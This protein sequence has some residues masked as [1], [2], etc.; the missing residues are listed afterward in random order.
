MERFRYNL[1]KSKH[2]NLVKETLKTLLL[3][4]MKDEFLESLN[5][6]GVGDVCHL[7]YDDVCKLCI[8]YSRGISKLGKNSREPSSQFLKYYT[9]IGVTN[10]SLNLQLDELQEGHN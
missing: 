4:G 9:K 7:S 6:I 5:I 3:K 10:A 1:Q 2:K 8:S